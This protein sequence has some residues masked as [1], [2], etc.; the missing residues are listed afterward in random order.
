MPNIAFVNGT[1]SRLEDAK[2]SI[3]DRGFQ[4]GDGVYEVIR[5]YGR[6]IFS[7]KEHLDRLEI[8][9][10]EIKIAL[11]YSVA[12]LEAFIRQGC[13]DS[14]HN[15][16]SIYIQLTRGVAPRSHAFPEGVRPT[17]VM[18]FRE[19]TQVPKLLRE[20]GVSVITV[21]DIRWERCH[22]KSLNLLPNVMAREAALQSGAYEAVFVRDGLVTEGAGSNLFAVFGKKVRTTPIGAEI[23]SGITR[24]IV[25]QVGL[26][27][28]LD[29]HEGQLVLEDLYQADELFITGTTIEVLPVVALDGKKIALG[30]P[31][32][33]TCLLEKAFQKY[34]H[35]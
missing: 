25:F 5:T 17:L 10:N 8:S 32:K 4:F 15:D 29:M 22:I 19:T 24:K 14:Q 1:W 33:T 3:D 11:P 21:P 6:S 27:A 16:V 2:I 7:L 18:T 28:G 20:Q 13:L 9:A 30:Q 12:E 31:G 26:T 23:L 35:G 34:V